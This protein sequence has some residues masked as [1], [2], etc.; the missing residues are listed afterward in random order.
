VSDLQEEADEDIVREEDEMPLPTNGNGGGGGGGGGGGSVSRFPLVARFPPPRFFAYT[1]SLVLH[2]PGCL[3]AAC[4]CL[5][6]P[7]FALPCRALPCPALPCLA[8]PCLA[9]LYQPMLGTPT[10]SSSNGDHDD[11]AR[12]PTRPDGEQQEDGGTLQQPKTPSSVLKHHPAWRT[13]QS[14]SVSAS[15]AEKQARARTGLDGE[16]PKMD[17]AGGS[18]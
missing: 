13:R 17:G 15:P 18:C 14:W 16:A 1:M 3:C 10:R 11:T 2:A 7:C 12:T 8:L 4:A 6:L 5:A 9:C